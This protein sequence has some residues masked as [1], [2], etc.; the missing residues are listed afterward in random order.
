[1]ILKA[2]VYIEVET[3]RN[4]DIHNFISVLQD[5]IYRLLREEETL[6]CLHFTGKG[7]DESKSPIRIIS[8]EQAIEHLRKSK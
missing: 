3:I 2:N 6:N 4:E 1:M 8:Y 5:H 7:K